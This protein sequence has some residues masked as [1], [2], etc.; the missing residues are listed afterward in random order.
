MGHEVMLLHFSFCSVKSYTHQSMFWSDLG[1]EVGYE[2]IGLV[3]S[4]LPTVGV[5][6]AAT[7]KDSPAA[8]QVE[9][10]DA[11]RADAPP[12]PAPVTSEAASPSLKAGEDYGKGVVFYLRDDV[13]VGVLLW[14]VFNKINIARKVLREN[15]KYED[16]SEVAK[17][18]N[19]HELQ[20]EDSTK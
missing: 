3:D 7:A 18:F 12:A 2:A 19:I 15:K 20:P 17:L 10:V 1:P 11:A 6:A 14:N 16:L 8:A 5:F 4:S 13:V 9:A